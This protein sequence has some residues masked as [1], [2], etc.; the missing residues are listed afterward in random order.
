[1]GDILLSITS[2]NIHRLSLTDIYI[3]YNKILDLEHLDIH[4]LTLKKI[5]TSLIAS[6]AKRKRRRHLLERR[7][8]LLQSL[9][10]KE[11]RSKSFNTDVWKTSSEE[12]ILH[13]WRRI[14]FWGEPAWPHLTRPDPNANL[15]PISS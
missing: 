2:M 10:V 5:I 4:I 12:K 3:T 1:M 7:G 6:E 11:Q 8:F 13:F 9:W 15:T 14:H